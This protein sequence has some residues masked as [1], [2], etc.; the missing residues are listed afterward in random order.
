MRG[1]IEAVPEE[2]LAYA[3][4]GLG[5]LTE[6]ELEVLRLTA[7]AHSSKQIAALLNLS[8]RTVEIYRS[9]ILNKLGARSSV[10]LVRILVQLQPRGDAA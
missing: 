6:R 10:D 9:R 5:T 1:V 7:N 2:T 8:H 3:R 4:H